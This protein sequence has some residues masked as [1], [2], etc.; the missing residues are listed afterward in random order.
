[1]IEEI[2]DYDNK[3]YCDKCRKEMDEG[4]EFFDGLEHYCSNECLYSQVSKDEYKEL[5]REGYAFWTTY[6][7]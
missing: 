5:H 1:M 3:I 4:Y 2:L 6:E 7:D